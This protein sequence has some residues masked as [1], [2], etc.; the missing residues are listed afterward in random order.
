MPSR[1]ARRHPRGG[2]S[3]GGR[4]AALDLEDARDGGGFSASAA[5][6]YTVSVGI[7]TSPPARSR[8]TAASTSVGD[9]PR[10]AHRP[11]RHHAG[12][13]SRNS[14]AASMK[15]NDSGVAKWSVRRNARSGRR[16]AR[17]RAVGGQDE[18]VVADDDEHRA[19]DAAD[20][21]GRERRRRRA[22]HHRRQRQRGRCPAARRTG[23]TGGPGCRRARPCP[24]RRRRSARRRVVALEH[25]AADAGEHEPAEPRPA[26]RSR[27]AAA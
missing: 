7:A 2:R 27:S 26:R 21:R 17:R 22:A 24:R 20:V 14:S 12:T 8:S 10:S 13:A 16:A 15:S 5:S 6:P 18:V 9:E 4:R 3:A 1:A 11:C 19:G 25:V 23:R